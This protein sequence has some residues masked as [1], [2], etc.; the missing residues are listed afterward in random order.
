MY[1]INKQTAFMRIKAMCNL[2]MDL[3]KDLLNN[4]PE[5]FIFNLIIYLH[6]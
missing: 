3:K 6:L 1:Y 4:C 5:L 2:N